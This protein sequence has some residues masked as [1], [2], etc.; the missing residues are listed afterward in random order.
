MDRK[1]LIE[2]AIE[3]IDRKATDRQREAGSHYLRALSG[4]IRSKAWLQE[5][6]STSDIPELLQPAINVQFL[7]QFAEYPTVWQEI[8]GD[9]IDS[10]RLGSVEF[11]DFNFSTEDLLGDHD[12]DTY[13]GMGLPGVGEYGEYPV[14]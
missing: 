13:T 11:G 14:A 3:T 4:D 5:G 6:I 1:H 9:V 10:P 8:V 2:S 12:G 7:A